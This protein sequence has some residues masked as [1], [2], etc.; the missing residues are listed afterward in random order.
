MMFLL[1]LVLGIGAGVY[2][3]ATVAW[4]AGLGVIALTVCVVWFLLRRK[5]EA[6]MRDP[7]KRK[8]LEEK[9]RAFERR[10]GLPAGKIENGRAGEA[11]ILKVKDTGNETNGNPRYVFSLRVRPQFGGEFEVEI[12]QVVPAILRAHFLP[13]K[14]VQVLYDPD[15]QTRINFVSYAAENG[16]TVQLADYPL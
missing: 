11:V 7:I 3:M 2:L 13:G 16:V 9:Q 12:E 4:P 14:I 15:D 5:K 1:L 10:L 6:L 8:I